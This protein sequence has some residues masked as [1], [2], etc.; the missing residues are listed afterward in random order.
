M[1]PATKSFAIFSPIA[2]CFSMLKLRSRCFTGLKPSLIFKACSVTS[3]GMLG[4]SEDF[5]VKMSLL[6]W[7]KL[8]SM[9]S[10]SEE[11]VVANAHHFALGATRV[12]EDLFG[13]FYRLERPV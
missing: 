12:Y 11:S 10:Y 13:A 4:M 2:L 7:R 6:A 5:H 1:S 8:T 9:L 3:L